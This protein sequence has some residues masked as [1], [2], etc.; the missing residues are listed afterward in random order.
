MHDPVLLQ[1]GTNVWEKTV[2]FISKACPE[3]AALVPP[4]GT[5]PPRNHYGRSIM[6]Y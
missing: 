2:H 3:K 1:Q 6:G 4:A 5:P